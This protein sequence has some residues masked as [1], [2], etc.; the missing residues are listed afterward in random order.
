MVRVQA[1]GTGAKKRFGR[2]VH[3][4]DVLIS[5]PFASTY[6]YYPPA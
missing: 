1:E 6:R 3:S 4:S 2:F 5:V